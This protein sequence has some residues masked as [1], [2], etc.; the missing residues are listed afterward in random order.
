M[1]PA[2]WAGT[3]VDLDSTEKPLCLGWVAWGQHGR[4]HVYYAAA[5]ARQACGDEEIG[6]RVRLCSW[7]QFRTQQTR[8]SMAKVEG[9]QPT[10]ALGDGWL[11]LKAVMDDLHAW[12]R[13]VLR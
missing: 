7:I 8:R 13:L 2:S 6:V 9:L 11:D 4:G 5:V 3:R 12:D 1:V 10:R